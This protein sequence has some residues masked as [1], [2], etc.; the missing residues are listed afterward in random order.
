MNK[1]YSE[2]SSFLAE[3]FI[4]YTKD[5]HL[6][7][8]TYFKMGGLAKIF[9]EPNDS[10]KFIKLLKF[11][12]ENK[13]DFRIIGFT[14]NIFFLDEIEYSV[15]ISTKNLNQVE[16]NKNE[17]IVDCGYA[18]SDVVRIALINSAEGFEGLEGIPA[19]VGGALFMNAGA[20]GSQIS[21][22]LKWVQCLDENYNLITLSKEEC[23]FRY[24]HSI[25]KDKKYIV[26]K[27]AFDFKKGNQDIIARRIEIYHIARH[28]YQNF[29]YPNLGSMISMTGDSYKRILKNNS[30]T[31]LLYWIFKII[32]RNPISKF[33][34]RKRPNAEKMNKLV[35]FY[36][37][38][39]EKTNI[40]YFLSNKNV[41]NLINTGKLN[42]FELIDYILLTHNSI[43]KKYYI[44][45]EIILNA[46]HQ[47]PEKFEKVVENLKKQFEL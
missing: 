27:A 1:I 28:S 38:N 24:R 18:L 8:N 32:F 36:Y 4:S 46:T 22:N 29:A 17:L 30:K 25:F 11:L 39:I 16:L 42:S 44:E 21:D 41:N 15:V 47:V 33:I 6:K 3:N 40:K 14:S 13:V 26:V 19:S 31:Y 35:K 12:F 43:G 5:F 37:S 23:D 9:I 2:I 7:Y 20:Y 10:E 45:N 34:M